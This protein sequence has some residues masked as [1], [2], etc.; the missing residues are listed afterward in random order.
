V[1]CDNDHLYNQRPSI[2][3]RTVRHTFGHTK[4]HI[5]MKN[6]NKHIS[7]ITIAM[8]A[9]IF[10]ALPQCLT[11]QTN[12]KLL[13][14]KDVVVKVMGSS[15]VHDWTM[16]A[17]GIESQGDF[18]LEDGRLRTLHSFSFAVE[19][20]S[21]KSEH[22]SMDNRTYKTIKADQFPQIVFKLTSAVISEDQKNKCDI[23]ATGD[24]TI[25]G[26][27]QVVV[28][29]VTAVVN[30]DNTIS[31]T[32][33]QKIKLTD[34]KID[35]PSFMLGAMKVTNDLTIQFNLVYKNNQ[36]LSKAN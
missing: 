15:N 10:V 28:L 2:L 34:Y 13:P 30:P 33:S 18:K 14:G 32:G 12:Y 17:T 4:K 35:P 31:C 27:S 3:S 6:L 23:K 9:I 26:V 20:K 16:T 25:S 24:L 22:S 5:K 8:A 11:A 21:L 29:N 36:L 7:A 1:I 19:A